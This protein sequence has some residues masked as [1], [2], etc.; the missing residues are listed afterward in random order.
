MHVHGNLSVTLSEQTLNHS[1]K[2]DGASIRILEKSKITEYRTRYR[3]RRELREE[4]KVHV[5]SA[6]KLGSKLGSD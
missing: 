1:S 4:K 2:I 6:K 3:T 5:T